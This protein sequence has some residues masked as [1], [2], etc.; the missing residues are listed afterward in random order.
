MKY[1][2]WLL[3]IILAATTASCS[4][5]SLLDDPD[6]ASSNPF[7]GVRPASELDNSIGFYA[8]AIQYRQPQRYLWE[9]PNMTT[10][11]SVREQVDSMLI[12]SKLCA[13]YV[14]DWKYSAE[15]N[16]YYW[17]NSKEKDNYFTFIAFLLTPEEV[18]ADGL[19]KLDGD[20][21]YL[22][23]KE[24]NDYQILSAKILFDQPPT[25]IYH[26]GSFSVEYKD[27]NNKVCSLTG[28][29]FKLIHTNEDPINGCSVYFSSEFSALKRKQGRF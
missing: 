5:L 16:T 12:Y 8:S 7:N 21:V 26:S 9:D 2:K 15:D 22:T 6:E 4:F 27:L 11:C 3:Y 14:P 10:F 19:A 24:K 13:Y 29:R 18:F 28:G 25:D 1:Y 20:R 17:N 23:D